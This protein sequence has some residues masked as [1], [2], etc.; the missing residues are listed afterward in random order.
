MLLKK[1]P[2]SSLVSKGPIG[3]NSPRCHFLKQYLLNKP[4]CFFKMHQVYLSIVRRH[5]VVLGIHQVVSLN[6]Q[7]HNPCPPFAFLIILNFLFHKIFQ[8]ILLMFCLFRS[9]SKR[10][11]A[12]TPCSNSCDAV[13][14]S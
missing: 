8:Q 6:S 2:K 7:S 13:V 9:P 1:I 11:F 10:D 12:K 4:S 14:T 3:L 5:K